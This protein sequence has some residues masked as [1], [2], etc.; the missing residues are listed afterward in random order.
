MSHGEG[1]GDEE[2]KEEGRRGANITGVVSVVV[3]QPFVHHLETRLDGWEYRV[4]C[5][6]SL[7]LIYIALPHLVFICRGP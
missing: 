1:G 7:M 4:T 2:R 3:S 5:I 6:L